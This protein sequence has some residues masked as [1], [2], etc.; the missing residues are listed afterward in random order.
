MN[1]A[2]DTFI[3]HEIFKGPQVIPLVPQEEGGPSRQPDVDETETTSV[4]VFVTYK[5]GTKRLFA[6]A[7][8]VLSP[9]EVEGVSFSSPNHR[10]M[11]S[12][13]RVKGD[14]PSSPIEQVQGRDIGKQQMHEESPTEGQDKDFVLVEE[15]Y[16]DLGFQS[17]KLKDMIIKEKDAEIQ[18]L[19]LDFETNGLSIFLGKRISNWKTSNLLWS[20]KQLEKI[21]K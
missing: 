4:P 18:A 11:L 20:Y 13:P 17:S 14:F 7:R 21:G 19:S 10:Q 15:D 1:I 5:R 16:T 9:P 6:T 2:W 3:A 8:R 12:S